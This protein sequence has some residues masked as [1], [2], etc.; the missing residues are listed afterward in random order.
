MVHRLNFPRRETPEEP[1]PLRTRLRATTLAAR[2]DKAPTSASN[3]WWVVLP[4]TDIKW[5]FTGFLARYR[6]EIEALTAATGEGGQDEEEDEDRTAVSGRKRTA[7]NKRAR[8]KK[9]QRTQ[10]RAS[11]AAL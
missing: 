4:G 2:K 1:Y 7:R 3:A 6:Q 5:Q 9:A 8:Q 11:S 10:A